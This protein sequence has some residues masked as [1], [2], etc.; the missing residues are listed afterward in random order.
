VIVNGGTG[1]SVSSSLGLSSLLFRV[2]TP[3]NIDLKKDSGLAI[4]WSDG[5]RSF[6]PIAYLRRMSPSA[7]M[8]ELREKVTKNRLTVIPNSMVRDPAA[9]AATGAE[10]VGNYAIRV[11]FSDGHSTGLY[12]WEYL[13]SIDPDAKK[14]QDAGRGG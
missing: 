5:T 6:Y 3:T 7:E 14:T 9:V 4:D 8:V 13:R 10:L 11:R 1:L 12:T 2:V